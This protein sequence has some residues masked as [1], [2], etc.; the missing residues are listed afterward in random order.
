MRF[1]FSICDELSNFS[2]FRRR[3]KNPIGLSIPYHYSVVAISLSFCSKFSWFELSPKLHSFRGFSKDFLDRGIY[4]IT[5]INTP[6][7]LCRSFWR[8]C[9]FFRYNRNCFGRRGSKLKRT[10]SINPCFNSLN[11]LF[12][13]YG[14]PRIKRSHSQVFF[15]SHPGSNLFSRIWNI[16]GKK[17]SCTRLSWREKDVSYFSI[18]SF[19]GFFKSRAPIVI[20]YFILRAFVNPALY[21]TNAEK[22]IPLSCCHFLLSPLS[23]RQIKGNY[24]SIYISKDNS[25]PLQIYNR[26]TPY[27]SRSEKI[28]TQRLLSN[29]AKWNHFLLFSFVFTTTTAAS[30]LFSFSLD[31]KLSC[32]SPLFQG[33]SFVTF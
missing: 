7:F 29:S 3:H 23:S 8:S 19:S 11:I 25:S 31:N 32:F 10:A 14:L 21:A 6:P 15:N 26:S 16:F 4:P 1:Y 17:S 12:E 30:K 2:C 18:K 24:G 28:I 22:W 9:I 13:S 27:I 5:Y 33:K 20:I